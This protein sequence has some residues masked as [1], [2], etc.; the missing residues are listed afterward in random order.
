MDTT[1]EF[2]SSGSTP[3]CAQSR[4]S[5]VAS[6]IFP[7]SVE[8]FRRHHSSLAEGEHTIAFV[9]SI[10]FRFAVQSTVS[11][12]FPSYSL[13]LFF[14]RLYCSNRRPPAGIRPPPWSPPPVSTPTRSPRPLF[15]FRALAEPLAVRSPGDDDAR[16]SCPPSALLRSCLTQ[17]RKR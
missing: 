16:S 8:L 3:W 11:W 15:P 14:V 10:L 5:D 2:P 17:G 9:S 7:N 4:E 12:S 1:L 6:V 13:C